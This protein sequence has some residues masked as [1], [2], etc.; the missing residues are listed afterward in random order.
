MALARPIPIILLDEITDF[1]ASS[2]TSEEVIAFKPSETLQ[3][4]ALHSLEGN[5]QN[6]L[7][8]EERV[9]MEEYLRLD[10]FMTLLKAKARLRQVR[11]G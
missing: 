6:F 8:P 9:E 2:P 1:L 10:H 11:K 5:R 3:R 4:R 7:T